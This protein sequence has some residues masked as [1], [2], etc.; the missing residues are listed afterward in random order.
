[1]E[2]RCGDD[3]SIEAALNELLAEHPDAL[4]AGVDGRGRFLP[5]PASISSGRHAIT[6]AR[7]ALELMVPED[8]VLVISTWEQA[9]IDGM[10]TTVVR[11]SCSRPTRQR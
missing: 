9:Q 8:R 1:M 11:L 4:V 5:L 10:A 6:D 3:D 7:R 2:P